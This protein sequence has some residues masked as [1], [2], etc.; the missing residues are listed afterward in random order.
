MN[1]ALKNL[2]AI[3]G[4]PLGEA[5][6]D[7]DALGS[8]GPVGRELSELLQMKNGCCAYE[9]ALIMRPLYSRAI[10]GILEWNKPSLWRAEYKSVS[11]PILCFAEDLFGIQFCIVDNHVCTFDPETGEMK[12]QWTSLEEWA[13]AILSDKNAMTGYPI[14]HE[15]QLINGPL[16]LGYRL[17]PKIPFV[18]GGEFKIE[19]LFLMEDARGML[20][21]ANIANQIHEIPDGTQIILQTKASMNPD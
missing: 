2:L 1:D 13:N 9:S 3:S 7:C 12:A 19:N 5:A 14:A 17:I 11:A 21:R 16:L 4:E 10:R 18:L 20:S 6:F 8:W 15:W